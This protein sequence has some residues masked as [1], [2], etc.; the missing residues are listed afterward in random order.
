MPNQ[1][2]PLKT[3]CKHGHEFTP[4][5]TRYYHGNR[6]RTCAECTRVNGRLRYVPSPRPSPIMPTDPVVLAY[7]AGIFD[8]EGSVMIRH[9]R[10]KGEA[11]K[12]Y[13]SL[14]VSVTSTDPRLTDW[15]VARFGG[16]VN[17]AGRA[18][19][20]HNYKRAYSWVLHSRGAEAFLR[21][22]RPYL[23]V[24]ADQTDVAFEFCATIQELGKGPRL[25][26]ALLEQRQEIR[27]R[28]RA[29]N[30]RGKPVAQ[31]AAA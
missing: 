20:N 5:N 14:A 17:S 4:E 31:D 26:A 2:G 9:L 16:T 23:I 25:T 28:L 11:E 15:L 12:K 8:G 30:A 27:A 22:V 6:G 13:H 10:K 21:V 24:K 7:A 29:L 19:I 3:H 18:H 1:Y